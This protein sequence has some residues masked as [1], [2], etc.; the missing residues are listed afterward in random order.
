MYF[1][2]YA[3]ATLAELGDCATRYTRSA[4]KGCEQCSRFEC[5][6]HIRALALDLVVL[7]D[8]L[9]FPLENEVE[10]DVGEVGEVRDEVRA[11]VRRAG[12]RALLELE[13]EEGDD[14]RGGHDDAC[15]WGIS[16]MP[17]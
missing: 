4:Q 17:K 6:A 12:R 5:E 1:V 16:A 7:L 8:V 15:V 13:L 2:M 14:L 3:V 10:V 11:H 9:R